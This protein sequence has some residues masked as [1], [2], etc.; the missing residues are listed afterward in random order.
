MPS[1]VF[2]S[3][4][5]RYAAA[6][7][8]KQYR[9]QAHLERAAPGADW[10][11]DIPSASL[12]FGEAVRV[13]VQLLGTESEQDGTWLWAWANQS[14]DNSGGILGIA[15]QLRAY[16]EQY[17]VPE[18]TQAELPLGEINGFLLSMVA[19][20]LFSADALYRGPYE[21][22][23]AFMLLTLPEIH[24]QSNQTPLHVIRVFTE[25]IQMVPLNHRPALLGYLEC[26]GYSVTEAPGRLQA[27]SPTGEPLEADFDA[28]GRVTDL[29]TT[30][31]PPITRE[32][33]AEPGTEPGGS[34]GAGGPRG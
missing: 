8:D 10:L 26:K 20:G 21:G 6:S 30:Q 15:E 22:G 29:R 7:L 23:A 28:Q 27:V 4:L 5:D 11:L 19:A 24:A 25:A 18:F 34:P 16:G 12:S 1:P 17:Q 13:P 9:L 33:Y 14:V 3:L 2:Q 31:Q 32:D